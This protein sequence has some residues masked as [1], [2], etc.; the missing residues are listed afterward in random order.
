M[1]TLEETKTGRGQQFSRS[2]SGG[3]QSFAPSTSASLTRI[4]KKD[5]TSQLSGDIDKIF[6][7]VVKAGAT[8]V[9]LGQESVKRVGLDARNNF[10]ITKSQILGSIKDD[11]DMDAVQADLAKAL[12]DGYQEMDSEESQKLFD[13]SYTN[14]SALSFQKAHSSVELQH[15]A[16]MKTQVGN[17]IDNTAAIN[18][19]LLTDSQVE[20]MKSQ[21]KSIG[22]DTSEVDYKITDNL[23]KEFIVFMNDN[24]SLL[25]SKDQVLNNNRLGSMFNAT[26]ERYATVNEDGSIDFKTD[27]VVIKHK[28]S[29]AFNLAKGAITQKKSDYNFLAKEFKASNASIST[30]S[31]N[32]KEMK[33]TI[34]AQEEKFKI[35]DATTDVS[36]GDRLAITTKFGQ[37]KDDMDK[38]YIIE[39][40]IKLGENI[41]KYLESGKTVDMVSNIHKDGSTI[42]TT[43]KPEEYRKVINRQATKLSNA[44]DAIELTPKTEKEFYSIVAE[45]HRLKQTAGV[46]SPMEKK[47]KNFYDSPTSQARSLNEIRKNAAFVKWKLANTRDSGWEYLTATNEKVSS[48][49]GNKNLTE[50][51]IKSNVNTIL[52]DSIKNKELKRNDRVATTNI[53]KALADNI[54]K[55][56]EWTSFTSI[57]IADGT[58]TAIKDMMIANGRDLNNAEEFTTGLE[59][60]DFGSDIFSLD[61]GFDKQRVIRPIGFSDSAFKDIVNKHLTSYNKDDTHNVSKD[62]MLFEVSYNKTTKKLDYT[63]KNAKD[64]SQILFFLNSS[65]NYIVK[66]KK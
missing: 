60:T 23:N 59:Y 20:T 35:I 5:T 54:S 6:G 57:P 66:G 4:A 44:A 9:K 26:Y 38:S 46:V 1:A 64:T 62:E 42:K 28:I 15:T 63:V 12:A 43:I 16:R 33:D 21:A 58:T 27:D 22:L 31:M 7:G 3:A 14:P 17:E 49:L 53:Q 47:Y 8:A 65:N 39:Q 19:Q 41:V 37:M 34:T 48:M 13:D 45:T 61:I 10:E 2:L 18:P 24:V 25:S 36:N 40:D 29:K 52:S 56:K 55:G 32:S 50:L 11:S 30:E 51:Q